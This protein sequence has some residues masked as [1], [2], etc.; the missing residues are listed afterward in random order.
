MLVDA[1]QIAETIHLKRFRNDFLHEPVHASSWDIFYV[2]EEEERF[3]HVFSYG[4]VVF[5]G[6]DAVSKSNLLDFIKKYAENPVN[7]DVNDYFT[8][9]VDKNLSKAVVKN[10]SITLPQVQLDAIRIIT[11]NVAQSVAMDYYE[12]L[13]LEILN[14][15]KVYIDQLE[16]FGKV[17]ISKRDLLRFI[18]KVKNIKNSIIDNLYILDDPNIVWD[19]EELQRLHRQLKDN[20]DISPR[21]RDLDYRLRIVEENLVLLTDLLQHRESSRL[22]WIIIILILVEVLN[23][24][25]SEWLRKLW[26]H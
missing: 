3:L 23:V 18:G 4:V 16:E 5:V 8:L 20:F 11:L 22:E 7:L 17:K 24:F 26:S 2:E 1:Y 25:F 15:S 10:D 13:S 9:L 6:Y 19:N 21:F 14:A 12:T